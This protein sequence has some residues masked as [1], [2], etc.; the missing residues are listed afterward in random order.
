MCVQVLFVHRK[1]LLVCS[2]TEESL[3]FLFINNVTINPFVLVLFCAKIR[4]SH[5]RLCYCIPRKIEM[6]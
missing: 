3:M 1:Y 5:A 4:K 2:L 6:E